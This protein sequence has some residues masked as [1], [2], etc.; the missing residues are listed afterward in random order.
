PGQPSIEG[1]KGVHGAMGEGMG[2]EEGDGGAGGH[3]GMFYHGIKVFKE[4]LDGRVLWG[5]RGG[6]DMH[7]S[8]WEIRVLPWKEAAAH[9]AAES[10]RGGHASHVNIGGGGD[11][12]DGGLLVRYQVYLLARVRRIGSPH[13]VALA[14]W[15]YLSYISC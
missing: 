14:T 7:R 13:T 15:R 8:M 12:S 1:S 11:G 3:G 5:L 10:V 4:I 2:S 6:K 9:L